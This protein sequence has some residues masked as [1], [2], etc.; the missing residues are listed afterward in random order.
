MAHPKNLTLRAQHPDFSKLNY[1]PLFADGA[2]AEHAVAF[3]RG[4]KFVVIVPRFLLKLKNE[5]NE[6]SLELPAGNWRNEFTG[7]QFD[8]RLRVEN[9]FREFP[10]ALLARKENE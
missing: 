5:W 2:K 9:L 7:E 1:E 6:T 4:G 8:G 10:V 3:S